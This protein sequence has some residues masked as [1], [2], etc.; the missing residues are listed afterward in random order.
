MKIVTCLLMAMIICSCHQRDSFTHHDA[1]IHNA[2]LDQLAERTCRAIIIRQQRFAL[3]NNIR[4][5]QDSLTSVNFRS[6]SHRLQDRLKKYMRQKDSLLKASLSLADNIRLQLDSLIPYGD[7][8]AQKRFTITL[9]S[10]LVK[11]GCMV[12]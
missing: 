12:K 1:V 6:D 9:D 11:K 5:T 2:K 7:K 4:F 10:L 3:A 8:G